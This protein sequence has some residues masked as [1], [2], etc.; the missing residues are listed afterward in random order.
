MS[1][2]RDNARHLRRTMTDAEK[3]LWNQLRCRRFA[4]FKF[5]R[6][7]PIGPYIA[8]FACWEGRL[9]VELDGAHHLEPDQQKHDEQRTDWL[10]RHG[11]RVL[12]FTN[13]AVMDEIGAFEDEIW[14]ALLKMRA[15]LPHIDNAVRTPSPPAPLPRGGEGRILIG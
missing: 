15:Q 12:R 6:Q 11:F 14:D 7:A 3:F 13:A 10:I 9:I 1:I 8:D 5:R 2:E 4:G